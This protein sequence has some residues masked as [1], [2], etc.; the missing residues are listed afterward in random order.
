MIT[1]VKSQTTEAIYYDCTE[2]KV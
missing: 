2:T 1:L